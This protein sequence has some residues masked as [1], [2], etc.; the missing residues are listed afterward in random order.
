MNIVIVQWD[1][2]TGGPSGFPGIPNLSIGTWAF[3]TDQRMY[4]L[5]WSVAF[6]SILLSLNLV[7][8]RAGRGLRA[9]H[10]VSSLQIRWECPQRPIR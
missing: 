9:L 6:A 4:F 3:N 5:I 7:Q 8:S 2:V 10:A 1:E